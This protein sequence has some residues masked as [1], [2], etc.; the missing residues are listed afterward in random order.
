MKIKF[1]LTVIIVSAALQNYVLSQTYYPGMLYIKVNDKTAIPKITIIQNDTLIEMEDATLKNIFHYN[2]VYRFC[3]SFPIIDSLKMTKKYGLDSVYRLECNCDVDSLM[4]QIIEN[5]GKYY[6]YI[7]KIPMY[8][9]CYTPDDYNIQDPYPVSGPDSSLNLINAQ[10]AWEYT[11]GDT[12]VKIGIVDKNITRPTHEDI[13]NQIVYWD[14]ITGSTGDFHGL[15]VSGCAAGATNNGVGKSSIGFNSKILFSSQLDCLYSVGTLLFLS[16]KMGA[17]VLNASWISQLYS[18]TDQD[19]I[20]IITE[21]GTLFVA[22]AGNNDSTELQYPA[23]YSNVLSVTSVG[24]NDHHISWMDVGYKHEH[25]HND[26]VDLCAPGYNVLGL[27][28]LCDTCYKRSS[29]TSFASPIVAGAAALIY[30]INPCLKPADVTYILK[31]T[32]NDVYQHPENV[33]F[34]GKLGAGRLDAGQAVELTDRLYRPRDYTI[35]NGENITWDDN[36]YINYEIVIKSGGRLTIKGTVFFNKK[37]VVTVERGGKLI[38]DGGLLTSNCKCSMWSGIDVWDSRYQSQYYQDQQGV[39]ELSNGAVIENAVTAIRTSR[40]TPRGNDP[41]AYDQDYTGGLI[42]ATNATF[43]NNQK[44]ILFLPYENFNPL[45]GSIWSNSS[46]F[47]QCTFETTG[48]LSDSIK[49][50]IHLVELN[51]VRNIRFY[52]CIFRNTT[53]SSNKE[54]LG[55]GIFSF[56]SSFIVKEICLDEFQPCIHEQPSKFINL[57]YGIKALGV[58]PT[59]ASTVDK[60]VFFRNYS[61]IFLA[62]TQNATITRDTF[63][64]KSVSPILYDTIG[65]LYLDQCNAYSVEENYFFS[66]YDPIEFGTGKSVGLAINNSNTGNYLNADN[67]IYN[68]RFEKLNYGILP[69]NKNRSNDGFHGLE[70]KCNDFIYPNEYDIAVTKDPGTSNMG[71]RNPQGTNGLATTDPA[72]NIFSYTWQTTVPYSDYYNEGENFVYWYHYLH[73]VADHVE[74]IKHSPTPKVNPQ[75]NPANPYYFV[76]NVSCPSSF[77]SGGGPGREDLIAQKN[78]AKEAIDSI[79][80]LLNLLVDGGDTPGTESY[81]ESSTPDQT[82]EVRTDLLGKT[83]YLSD[84]VMITAAAKE[85]VLPPAIITEI[86]S[87]NPQAAKSDTVMQILENRLPPLSDDQ[88]ATIEEGI[89]VI[90]AKESL[91]TRLAGYRSQYNNIL[92]KIILFYKND[93]LNLSSGDSVIHYLNLENQLWAKYSLVF[94]YLAKGDTSSAETTLN[95]IPG[96]FSLSAPELKEHQQYQSFFALLKQLNRDGKSITEIDSSQVQIL[97][98]IFNSSNGYVSGYAKNILVTMGKITYHEPYVFPDGNLKSSKI[99]RKNSLDEQRVNQLKVYP[100]PAKDYIIVE[101][102]LNSNSDDVSID[103]YDISGKRIR[104][105]KVDNTHD[106]LVVPLTDLPG[107]N[108]FGVITSD[109]KIDGTVKFVITK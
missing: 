48:L 104:S 98:T 100:N 74:P 3:R 92:K 62:N 19:I 56:N 49:S 90:G 18:Q 27:W 51:G 63:N 73:Q 109:M 58:D 12:S 15:F 20:N 52:G 89:F 80:N 8:E 28:D 22:A 30:S 82:L 35:N 53:V 50:P 69:M 17:K 40:P 23:S 65:G 102:T 31:S 16:Y 61:G 99:I 21:N 36:K 4:N 25:N 37:A 86:L 14:T 46:R 105:I 75:Y 81:V 26:S 94:E 83:P 91:E 10:T 103:L 47:I 6:K 67:Q 42:Y 34:L 54:N 5:S 106:W 95:N 85:D 70:I 66:I 93:T 29:G 43:R 55:N 38:V 79:S 64:V 32:A 88:L 107:G 9:L 41:D 24:F 13:Q 97:E 96:I 57:N 45:N 7:E 71:I 84:S 108:Y 44:A 87:A 2:K 76:K 78:D 68:N 101:Y 39:V 1:I 77:I 72:G 59:K 33:Q 60:S 11:H